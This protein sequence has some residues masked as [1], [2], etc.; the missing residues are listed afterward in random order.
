MAIGVYDGHA[1]LIKNIKSLV[2]TY[3]CVHCRARFTQAC[4]LQRHTKTCAQGKTRI[5]CP[6]ERVEAP[7]TVYE[8]AFYPKNTA[9][10][11]SLLWLERESEKREIHIHHAMCWHGGERWIEGAPVEGCDPKTRT[12]F[13]YHGCYWHGCPRCY[14]RERDRII[15]CSKK[16]K[17]RKQ[18]YQKAVQRTRV[19]RAACYPVI[20]VWECDIAC[21]QDVELLHSSK[22]QKRSYPH[23]ILY[24]FE[25]YG[26][27]NRR[28]E[29]TG[30]LTFENIRVPISVTVGDTLEREPT[31]ICERDPA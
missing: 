24:D 30:M 1:F 6:N 25:A 31:H 8:M 10:R 14:P 4:N 9:S 11:Q 28:K 7:Q 19:F 5:E 18:L 12:V 29:P 13:Q 2:R 22:Q 20:E 3:A 21:K 16:K 26:E 23:A 27:K 15:T 17:N